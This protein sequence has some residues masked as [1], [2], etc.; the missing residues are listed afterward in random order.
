MFLIA[1]VKL[2]D[3][4]HSFFVAVGILEHVDA[5]SMMEGWF[6]L[7]LDLDFLS[8]ATLFLLRR[9]NCP[10]CHVFHGV[11]VDKSYFPPISIEKWFLFND[12]YI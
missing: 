2:N 3:E 6:F 12:G 4:S 11:A 8:F 10:P 5:L 9:V 1:M 7:S